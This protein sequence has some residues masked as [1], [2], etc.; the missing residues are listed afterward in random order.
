MSALRREPFRGDAAALEAINQ[1]IVAERP[2]F[3]PGLEDLEIEQLVSP[4]S[5]TTPCCWR[6]PRCRRRPARWR[7]C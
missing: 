7:W 1:A 4:T 2:D 5:R 3:E 6:P